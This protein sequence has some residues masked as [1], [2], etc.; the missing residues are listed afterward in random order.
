MTGG[1]L[2]YWLVEIAM[3]VFRI[4]GEAVGGQGMTELESCD[5]AVAI[6]PD[7]AETSEGLELAYYLAER[8]FAKKTSIAKKLKYEFLL[9]LAGKTDIR[10]AMEATAPGKDGGDFLVVVFSGR[11]AG[12]SGRGSAGADEDGLMKKLVA[13]GAKEAKLKKNASPL[14]LERISLSRLK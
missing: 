1:L 8:A 10:S 12:S 6:R 11:G 14:A 2:K 13:L 3:Q 4:R 7:A 9:W 5:G